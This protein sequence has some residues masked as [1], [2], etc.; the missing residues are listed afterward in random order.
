MRESTVSGITT[1]FSTTSQ[2][3]IGVKKLL[4]SQ[5]FRQSFSYDNS[6]RSKK[7]PTY[8]AIREISGPPDQESPKSNKP[9]LLTKRAHRIR[10]TQADQ[11]DNSTESLILVKKKTTT[12]VPNPEFADSITGAMK[13][14]KRRTT[15]NMKGSQS[16]L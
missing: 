5:N 9:R 2:V 13:L 1:G 4:K 16:P 3:S 15:F 6:P 14:T 11:S 8:G 12:V 10:I 7:M